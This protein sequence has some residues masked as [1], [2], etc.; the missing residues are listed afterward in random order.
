MRF[1]CGDGVVTSGYARAGRTRST[2]AGSGTSSSR[3][4]PPRKK[5]DGDHP[6][7]DRPAGLREHPGNG[8][9]GASR[10]DA[11]RIA[12][13]M[14]VVTLPRG[15]ERARVMASGRDLHGDAAERDDI[16]RRVALH[17][18]SPTLFARLTA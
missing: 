4:M 11:K 6:F 16:D 2:C 5:D 12:D 3:P 9:A 15:E 7:G 14:R 17:P 18:C 13:S 8:D 10:V 1:S